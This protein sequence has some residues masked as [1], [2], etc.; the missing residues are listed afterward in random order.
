MGGNGLPGHLLVPKPREVKVLGSL[1]GL[2]FVNRYHLAEM[3]GLTVT[4]GYNLAS[5]WADLL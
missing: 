2:L 5:F 3:E 4:K 1:E